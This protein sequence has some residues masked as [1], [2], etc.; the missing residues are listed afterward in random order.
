MVES[1]KWLKWFEISTDELESRTLRYEIMHNEKISK[2]NAMVFGALDRVLEQLGVVLT[3]DIKEQQEF[4]GIDVVP[5]NEQWA[6]NVRGMVV[7]KKGSDGL[8]VPYAWV[9]QAKIESSGDIFC[10]VHLF[11]KNILWEFHCGVNITK[12]E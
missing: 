6:E 4:L 1:K 10:E 5:L 11:D 8:P 9:S 3:G 2:A 12:V 7:S